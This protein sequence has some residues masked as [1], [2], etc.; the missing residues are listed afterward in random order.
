MGSEIISIIIPC[1]NQGLYIQDAL[2]SLKKCDPRLYEVII[3][4]DGSSDNYTNEYLKRLSENGYHVIFQENKGLGEAR[5]VGIAHSKGQYILPLDADN[6]ILPAYLEDSFRIFS[7]EKETAV[8]YGNAGYFGQKTG[9]LKPGHFNLQRMMLGNYIDACAVIRKSVLEEVG[10]Y[11]N[12]Q[13]MGFEDWDLW[14]RIAFKEYKFH[15]IDKVLFEYRVSANSMIK[16]LTADIKK[17]NAIKD[18]FLEKYPDKL[19]FSFV[20]EKILF[21]IKKRFFSFLYA[22]IL[23]RFFPRYYQTLIDQSK[24][25]KGLLYDEV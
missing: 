9:V 20:E 15:Y 7:K 18:Y 23:K 19:D 24:I 4:N 5:N 1:Y 11:D 3:I 12:M 13:I 17:Q 16:N 21:R 25:Y 8:V 6:K 2:D 22:R 14:L 10:Y